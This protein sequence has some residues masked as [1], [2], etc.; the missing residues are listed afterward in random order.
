MK[1][2]TKSVLS[3]VSLVLALVLVSQIVLVVVLYGT[4]VIDQKKIDDAVKVFRGELA[5]IDEEEEAP[6]EEARVEIDSEKELL[7]A[8]ANWRKQR[9]AEEEALSLRKES[10]SAMLRE[11]ESVKVTL[12]ASWRTFDAEREAFE[13]QRAARLAAERDENFKASVARYEKMDSKVTA[14]LLYGLSD[15]EVLRYL[16]A[17]KTSLAAEILTEIKKVDE[18]ARP[19]P[20]GEFQLNRAAL[21]QQMLSGDQVALAAPDDAYAS[22]R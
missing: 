13:A 1:G 16:R 6:E 18:T 15:D 8:V 12:E 7:A 9:A 17:F 2:A 20:P 4:G 5:S 22:G 14:E 11:L 3:I 19:A 21:L 10:A